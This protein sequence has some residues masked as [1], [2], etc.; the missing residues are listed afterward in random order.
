MSADLLRRAATAMRENAE[1]SLPGPW[2]R[3]HTSIDN[4]GGQV[5]ANVHGFTAHHVAAWDPTVALAVA[6]WLDREAELRVEFDR[7]VVEAGEAG[8]SVTL[9]KTSF[10]QAEAVARAYLREA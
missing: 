10:P 1:R 5:A 9:A 6:D 2:E 3:V 4:E 7:L 8:F